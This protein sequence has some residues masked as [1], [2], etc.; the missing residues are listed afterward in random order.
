MKK[1]IVWED[2]SL[3]DLTDEWYKDWED[4]YRETEN[5]PET[6]FVD[7]EDVYYYASLI[8]SEYLQ[9]EIAN[10]KSSKLNCVPN[11]IIM[12]GNISRWNESCLGYLDEP[13]ES[14]DGCLK[15][16]LTKVLDDCRIYVNEQ[17]DLI[18]E[19]HHH[20]GVN[21]FTYREWKPEVTEDMKETVK[22]KICNEQDDSLVF[23]YT[24][25]LGDRIR[26]IYGF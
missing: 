5:I 1:L 20:D 25:P 17:N 6:D 13:I 10:F 12:F 16:L 26:S 18:C 3:Q 19:A 11:G 15:T 21:R 8:N 9:D 24:V 22:L 2:V 4:N 7:N 14:L 23:E